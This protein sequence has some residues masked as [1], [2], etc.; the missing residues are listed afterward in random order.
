M[1]KKDR[2]YQST[3][4]LFSDIALEEVALPQDC[5]KQK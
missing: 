1:F 5:L 4:V 3:G 2:E